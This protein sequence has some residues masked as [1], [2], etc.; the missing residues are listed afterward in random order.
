[1]GIGGCSADCVRTTGVWGASLV[2]ICL[3][4]A[5]RSRSDRARPS[6]NDLG[7]VRVTCGIHS[8]RPI[9]ATLDDTHAHHRVRAVLDVG[10]DVVAHHD[11]ATGAWEVLCRCAVRVQIGRVTLI[12]GVG[13]RG[14]SDRDDP[15]DEGKNSC[16]EGPEGLVRPICARGARSPPP[17]YGV[18]LSLG[19]PPTVHESGCLSMNLGMS[20][21][22][23][24]AQWCIEYHCGTMSYEWLAIQQRERRRQRFGA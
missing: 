1:M 15:G 20:E 14:L 9:G 7:T 13:Q 21:N 16:A 22:R 3:T 17:A 24:A 2:D 4:S 18:R 8:R 11:E 12:V 19:I 23:F 10:A 6:L 5:H